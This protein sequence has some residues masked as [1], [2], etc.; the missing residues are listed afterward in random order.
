MGAGNCVISCDLVIFMDQAA[1]PVPP[2]HL[3]TCACWA[4]MPVPC[5]RILLQ[6]PVRPVR[7][8]VIGVLAEN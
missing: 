6:G 5:G 2:Q 4:W 7:V 3:D 8:A 1:E